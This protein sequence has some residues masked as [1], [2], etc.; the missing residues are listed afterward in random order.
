MMGFISA[1]LF[2]VRKREAFPTP[3]YA[4][5]KLERSVPSKVGRKSETAGAFQIHS[6]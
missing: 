6:R 5:D 4:E 3:P 1:S 2:P